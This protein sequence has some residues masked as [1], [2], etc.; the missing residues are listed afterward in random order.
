MLPIS[1]FNTISDVNQFLTFDFN[2]EFFQK[3][4][5][6]LVEEK[7]KYILVLEFP[8][9]QKEN[10]QLDIKENKISIQA[11]KKNKYSE[12]AKFYCRAKLSNKK[13]VSYRLPDDIISGS[14]SAKLEN[15]MLSVEFSK[16]EVIRPK[17]IA[18]Q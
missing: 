1:L 7:D 3:D 11:E 8:G 12:D 2:D 9:F 6:Q 16:K 18:I 13:K 4:R 14:A 10:I 17:K 15:G 5:V